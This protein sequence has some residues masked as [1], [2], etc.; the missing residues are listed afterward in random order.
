MEFFH[1][2]HD[3]ECFHIRHDS[4]CFHIRH[5]SECFH[6]RYGNEDVL[7]VQVNTGRIHSGRSGG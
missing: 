3:S 2:R 5:D 6:I 4:E 7:V 1:I